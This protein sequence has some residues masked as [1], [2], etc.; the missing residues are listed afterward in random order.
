MIIF[1]QMFFY[2]FFGEGVFTL[3]GKP[4]FRTA[5]GTP[6]Q[7]LG[8]VFAWINR[9]IASLSDECE[10]KSGLHFFSEE[11]PCCAPSSD[12]RQEY[13]TLGRQDGLS[14][15]HHIKPEPLGEDL[16]GDECWDQSI[17]P[18]PT[19]WY[20]FPHTNMY[21]KRQNQAEPWSVW[22]ECEMGW[23]HL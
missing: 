14:T 20:E 5:Y 6:A 8:N 15:S 19:M 21:L 10:M 7:W 13:Y 17:S 18:Y 22:R 11:Y 3:H 4:S 9:S 23:S 16:C 12:H 2:L 1:S